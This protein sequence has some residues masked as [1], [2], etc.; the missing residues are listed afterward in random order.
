MEEDFEKWKNKNKYPRK[1]KHF[2]NPRKLDDVLNYLLNPENIVQHSFYPFL[3][4][5]KKQSKFKDG[6]KKEKSE[7][8]I[9][10]HI[11]TVMFIRIT[12]SNLTNFITPGPS[13]L[14]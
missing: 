1:Y 11:S 13:K 12:H 2:D 14:G 4:F 6:E 8:C 10:A 3:H 5:V 9:I 7:S